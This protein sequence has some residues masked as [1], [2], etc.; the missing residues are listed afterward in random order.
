MV[1]AGV[2]FAYILNS[3]G[4]I[5]D[6]TKSRLDFGIEEYG[7]KQFPFLIIPGGL[8]QHGSQTTVLRQYAIEGGVAEQSVLVEEL[9]LETAME[10]FRAK[11]VIVSR[12]MQS[13]ELISTRKHLPRI[14]EISRFFMPHMNL[15]YAGPTQPEYFD[16]DTEYEKLQKFYETFVGIEAGND[17]AI[18]RRFIERQPLYRDLT[19]DQLMRT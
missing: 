6:V 18:A 16:G 11:R 7:K 10:V 15:H 14:V 13:A 8:T 17:E 4:S 19:L 3:D 12:G 9:A 2:V 5:D 1:N